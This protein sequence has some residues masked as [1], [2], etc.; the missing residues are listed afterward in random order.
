MLRKSNVDATEPVI[1]KRYALD[2]NWVFVNYRTSITQV[3][4][5]PSNKKK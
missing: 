2:S 1:L 3:L 5:A 4:I